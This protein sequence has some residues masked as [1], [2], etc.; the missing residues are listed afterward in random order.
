MA[1]NGPIILVEDDADDEE[2]F[3][4][5][6]NE[7]KILNKLIWFRVCDDAFHYL[8]TTT[9][10]PLIIF[11]DMNLPR[12]SGIEFKRRIDN[13]KQLRQRSIPF[14]FY[15]TTIQK[16]VVT[17][18]YTQLTVQGFFQKPFQYSE[19]KDLL[20]LILDYWHVCKHPNN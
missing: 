18:A 15:T 6:L 3:E 11:S 19:M 14:V 13:D 4:T 20:K 12:E 9:D 2:L 10:Q 7:L 17:E 8:K 1:R 16:N 5:A